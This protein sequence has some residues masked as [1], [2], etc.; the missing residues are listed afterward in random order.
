[1]NNSSKNFSENEYI[2]SVFS[3]KIYL[4]ILLLSTL[5]VLLIFLAPFLMTTGGTGEKISSFIYLFFSKVCH[6]DDGR[7][8][9]LFGHILG[10][11]SRCVWIYTG[12]FIGISSYPLIKKINNVRIPSIW[13]LIIPVLIL[14][15]DVLAD[16]TGI[17][18][19]TFVS[20]SV[21]GFLIGF[22]LVYFLY[23]GFL[24][25]FYEVN[26]FLKNKLST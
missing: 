23:P 4:I 14:G 18:P 8:F 17:F 11:C 10:V 22:V 19:N 25:F 24:K 9:H 20:R 2:D 15:A 1:M 26:H 16:V 12:F 6:Q 5:W 3:K 7:S 21:T 13:Y